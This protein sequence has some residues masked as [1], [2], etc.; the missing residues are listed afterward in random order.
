MALETAGGLTGPDHHPP[1][2]TTQQDDVSK[3]CPVSLP[4][5]YRT[6]TEG[7]V[8]ESPGFPK[9]Q[10]GQPPSARPAVSRGS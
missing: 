6:D 10:E 7:P 3:W 4:E 9:H 8:L 5:S 2:G 1:P